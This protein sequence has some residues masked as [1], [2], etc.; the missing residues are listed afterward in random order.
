MGIDQSHPQPLLYLVLYLILIPVSQ[1]LE[2]KS[3]SQN[4]ITPKNPHPQDEGLN[5]TF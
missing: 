2:Q 4:K 1:L 5:A 3:S